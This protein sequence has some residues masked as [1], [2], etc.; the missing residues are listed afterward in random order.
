MNEQQSI[1]IFQHLILFEELDLAINGHLKECAM[2]LKAE[3][4]IDNPYTNKQRFV[5]TDLGKKVIKAGGWTKYHQQQDKKERWEIRY[6][7]A[8]LV[9]TAIG[10]V[11]TSYYSHESNVASKENLEL[12]DSI[13]VKNKR[14]HDDSIRIQNYKRI[15]KIAP[16]VLT[17]KSKEPILKP[18]QSKEQTKN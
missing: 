10:I 2:R 9:V 14:I 18:T 16:A 4:Y 11:A 1:D 6:K 8:I 3:K 13:R 12:K 7:I 17:D 5:P 15:S